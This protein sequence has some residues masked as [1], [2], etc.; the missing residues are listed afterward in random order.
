MSQNMHPKRR[1]HLSIPLPDRWGTFRPTFRR[2]GYCRDRWRIADSGGS[3][4]DQNRF[5]PLQRVEQLWVRK[6]QDAVSR[7]CQ[8]EGQERTHLLRVPIAAFRGDLDS[9][10]GTSGERGGR[11]ASQPSAVP[12]ARTNRRWEGTEK[13]VLGAGRGRRRRCPPMR[14]WTRGLSHPQKSAQFPGCWSG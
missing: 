3:A 4:K 6:C 8:T 7:V 14:H 13:R 9:P 12:K 2:G 1:R 5:S 10:I 11:A